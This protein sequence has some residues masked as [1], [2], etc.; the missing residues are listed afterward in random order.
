MIGRHPLQDLAVASYV[1]NDVSLLGGHDTSTIPP[2]GRNTSTAVTQIPSMLL[3]T[4]PN[5]SGKS[6]YL[7]QVKGRTTSNN[8]DADGTTGS[9]GCIPGSHREV[10]QT[11][12]FL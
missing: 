11:R 3:L 2:Y 8:K 12:S 4:G 6:I 10:S 5:Y 7:K 1:P 9:F